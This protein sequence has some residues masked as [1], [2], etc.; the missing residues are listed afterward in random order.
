MG[1]TGRMGFAG[2]QKWV[3]DGGNH[4][5]ATVYSDSTCQSTASASGFTFQ[6]QV[7]DVCDDDYP[8]SGDVVCVGSMP[9]MR[10]YESPGCGGGASYTGAWPF[11]SSC[12]TQVLFLLRLL[13]C[14]CG[15]AVN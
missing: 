14:V 3:C 8:G 6:P 4:P 13:P 5:T 7:Y 1:F 2:S 15:A 12:F 10:F 11:G 9:S